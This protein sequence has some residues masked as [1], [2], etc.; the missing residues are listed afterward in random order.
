MKQI[1]FDTSQEKE[2][3]IDTRQSDIDPIP[4]LVEGAPTFSVTANIYIQDMEKA[5]TGIEQTV[6]E[7][8]YILVGRI[9]CLL[10]WEC[11]NRNYTKIH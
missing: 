1:L 8:T 10:N 7:R 9:G 4:I 6:L 3:T 2:F 5:F 11:F